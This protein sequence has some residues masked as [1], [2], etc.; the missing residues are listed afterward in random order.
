[1]VVSTLIP[2]VVFLVGIALVVWSVEEFVEHVAEA[3]VNLGVSTFLLTV[4]L[5]GTDLENAVLGIAAAAGDLPDVALG[6]VFGEALFVLG[7][8]VGL[9]G[10]AVPFEESTPREYLALTA[11]SPALLALLSLD[12]RLSRLDGALL[13][14]AFAPLLWA[15]YRL[16]SSR[17]TRFLEAEDAEEIEADGRGADAD[18]DADA[19]ADANTDATADATDDADDADDERELLEVGLVLLAI[20]GM[21]AGS[22]LAVM[23]AR[24]ILAAFD[25]VG[26]A[27]GATVMSFIASLEELLLTVEPVREGRPAVGIG[28]VVGSTLFFVTANAGAIALVRTLDLSA[29]VFAVHWPFFLGA[30]ALVLAFLFRGRVGRAEGAV[31]LAV[32]AGYWAANYLP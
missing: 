25:L 12:G 15:V 14:V 29:A 20:V 21:T 10:V 22:Q 23:G 1:M 19:D 24:D 26:L 4:V 18:V 27:F 16:E 5:A 9:A 11:L 17:S 2:V 32:Y 6:T 8:A 31:L 13:L 7:A 30:L 3:A 28:N